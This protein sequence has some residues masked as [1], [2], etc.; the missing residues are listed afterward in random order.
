MILR[1]IEIF[2]FKSI[3]HIEI[4]VK[5]NKICFVGMNES[6]KSSI[7]E[8]ISYLNIQKGLSTTLLNKQ[9]KSYPDGMPC[10]AGQFSIDKKA[11]KAFLKYLSENTII[12]VGSLS[13]ENLRLQFKRW[14]N[15]FENISIHLSE[16]GRINID[17]IRSLKNQF[18]KISF[19]DKFFEQHYPKIELFEREELLL[20]PASAE[21]LIG[22]DP[23]FETFRRLLKIG[24]CNDFTKLNVDTPSFFATYTKTIEKKINSIF[25][26]HYRQDQSISL[27]IVSSGRKLVLLINDESEQA[28]DLTER[29]PGFQYYFAFLVNKLYYNKQYHNKDVILLLD[30]PG[31]NL[32]PKGAKDLLKTFDE[33]S[34]KSLLFYTTHNPF[35]VLRNDLDSLFYVQKKFGNGTKINTKPWLNKYQIL[36]KELGI[37]LNDSFLIGDINLIVEG[38]TEKFAL[39]RLFGDS[40]SDMEWINIFDAGGVTNVT[41][42]LNYLG[43][44]NLNQSG[45]VLLDS[46]LEAK[47]E[48][49][50]AQFKEI[51]DSSNWSFV[52]INDVF[53]NDNQNRTFEDIFP[54]EIYVAAFNAYCNS[55][56]PLDV[57]NVEYS[58]YVYS[59]AI[60]TPIVKTLSGHFYSFVSE[61]N[62]N[63]HSITKQSVIREVFDIIGKCELDIQ[64]KH[65]EKLQDLVK[66][67]HSKIIRIAENGNN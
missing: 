7:I 43:P 47:S 60:Q 11:D 19:L 40:G 1:S 20:E 10:I 58:D 33:I 61:D 54:Q 25:K 28:F 13:I 37:L 14:G 44:R 18:E 66:I 4:D 9:S 2:E 57:F 6:G 67:I 49:K 55:L 15:G 31:N 41:Q 62:K 42:I 36:R 22:D 48:Q 12:D 30:E 56:K 23:A 3:K 34:A 29:S 46:D 35:L 63:T 5:T 50:R 32:H 26:R 16:I 21:D 59:G 65:M 52:E 8:A 39:H 64:N 53:G 45:V 24:D 38:A 27:S 17:V 51:M